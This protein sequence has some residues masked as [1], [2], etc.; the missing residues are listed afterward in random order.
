MLDRLQQKLTSLPPDV[1]ERVSTTVGDMQSFA[2][3]ERFAL[4]V[5]PFRAFLHNLTEQDQLACLARWASTC[6]RAG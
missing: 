1:R 6:A 4:V 2:L 5:A 3:A